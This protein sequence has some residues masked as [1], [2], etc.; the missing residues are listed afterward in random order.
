MI[1]SLLKTLAISFGGGLALG[2][3]IK[4]GQGPAKERG[5][6]EVDLN[7]LL[8]R[9]DD[10]EDRI[11]KVES[12]VLSRDNGAPAAAAFDAVAAGAGLV[13]SALAEQSVK[14]ES[15]AREMT[16]LRH[17][18]QMVDRRRADQM[19]ELGRKVEHL[20]TRLPQIVEANAGARFEE[21]ERKL[22][23]NF[24]EAQG[25][26]MDSFV[27]TIQT[28]VVQRISTLETSLLEQSEAIGK[29]REASTK[30]DLNLQKMLAGIER[31]CDQSRPLPGPQT[32]PTDP[33]IGPPPVAP[34]RPAPSHE[35]KATVD[36]ASPARADTASPARKDRLMATEPKSLPFAA[37]AR[38]SERPAEPTASPA[39]PAAP[40]QSR[41]DTIAFKLLAPEP[42]MRKKWGFPLILGALIVSITGGVAGLRYSGAFHQKMDSASTT[43][44]APTVAPSGSQ[45]QSLQERLTA[46]PNDE[47][48]LLELAREYVSRKDWQHAEET[49]RSILRSNAKNREAVL[50]L[51]DVLYQEQKYEES[52]AVLNRL[53]TGTNP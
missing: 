18:M 4:L 50:G 39:A 38:Q 20:E 2:A 41:P 6:A 15:H 43:P 35:D 40:E 1:K 29:L 27:Q 16:S 12:T 34:P 51:S 33:A 26:S 49:Y 21:I 19:T 10:V 25:R 24:E 9:L 13:E 17:E 48:A 52:A 7:P 11:V 42:K 36:T 3:G 47:S 22:Q 53:S 5:S 28:R 31:L 30:T 8:D 23:K 45:L 37:E 14:L 44:P 46:K 32:I